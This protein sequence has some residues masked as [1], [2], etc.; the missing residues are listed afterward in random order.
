MYRNGNSFHPCHLNG[1]LNNKGNAFK[2][3][4]SVLQQALREWVAVESDSSD[5]TKRPDL[6][7]MMDMTAEKLKNMGGEVEMVDIGSQEVRR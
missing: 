5:A 6:H 7:R 2:A 4:C 1:S 3:I